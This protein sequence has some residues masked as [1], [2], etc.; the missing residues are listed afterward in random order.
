MSTLDNVRKKVVMFAMAAS[1]VYPHAKAQELP[2]DDKTPQGT[3]QSSTQKSAYNKS[4]LLKTD[5]IQS[6]SGEADFDKQM[7]EFKKHS[8]DQITMDSKG[9][10]TK[11]SDEAAQSLGE[12]LHAYC[13]EHKIMILKDGSNMPATYVNPD[14][15]YGPDLNRKDANAK[16]A[17]IRGKNKSYND[18]VESITSLYA[19]R[20][21]VNLEGMKTDGYYGKSLP[22]DLKD[23]ERYISFFTGVDTKDTKLNK[24]QIRK[25]SRHLTEHEATRNVFNTL[26]AIRN[27]RIGS[28]KT[29]ENYFQ[30]VAN[31]NNA[32]T[33]FIAAAGKGLE[34][35]DATND[36]KEVSEY[37]GVELSMQKSGNHYTICE[38]IVDGEGK[39]SY[40]PS[41][42][43][44][45]KALGKVQME[46]SQF[47]SASKGKTFNTNKYFQTPE[48]AR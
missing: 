23:I 30:D 13:K 7:K 19:M 27:E 32:L 36:L 45:A 37:L 41:I 20:K 38:K 16:S 21:N 31:A 2:N 44:L 6:R 9:K 18:I 25:L 5:L 1:S 8:G 35:K 3:Q 28:E 34:G 33:T 15:Y 42:P 22:S 4:F 11:I 10:I 48:T 47:A 12:M 17:E 46:E 26:E 14:S 29:G 43:T 24:D 39:T 40:D